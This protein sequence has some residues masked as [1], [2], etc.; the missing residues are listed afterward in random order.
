ME[1][2]FDTHAHYYDERFSREGEGVDALLEA[3]FAEG[4]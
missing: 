4:V 3:L 1:K 2:L